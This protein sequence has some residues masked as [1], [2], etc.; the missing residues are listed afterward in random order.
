VRR[1]A[2]QVQASGWSWSLALLS[3]FLAVC[4]GEVLHTLQ[5]AMN[6]CLI[7]SP[8]LLR[9]VVLTVARNDIDP[10]V[11]TVG[12]VIRSCSKEQR[13]DRLLLESV[14]EDESPQTTDMQRPAVGS[15]QLADKVGRWRDR[16]H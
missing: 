7:V 1:I 2:K 11:Q 15:S 8:L 14:A 3:I 12:F 6:G 5:R 9:M 16:M 4:L 10:P 13:V